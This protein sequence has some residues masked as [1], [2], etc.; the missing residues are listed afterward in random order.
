MTAIKVTVRR[1]G[2]WWMVEVPQI[3]G[4][5]QARHVSEVEEMAR[6]LIT[7][8]ADAVDGGSCDLDIHYVVPGVKIEVELAAIARDHERARDMEARAKARRARVMAELSARNVPIRD[9]AELFD[10][11]FQR[12]HQI[13]ADQPVSA[14]G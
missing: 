11:S 12:V 8:S 1:D 13:L 3:N 7:M 6:S 5:T 4:L 14:T 2:K 10:M 9:I